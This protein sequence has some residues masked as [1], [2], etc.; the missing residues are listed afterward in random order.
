ML[1]VALAAAQQM[2]TQNECDANQTESHFAPLHHSHEIR[3]QFLEPF[4]RRI[5][6]LLNERKTRS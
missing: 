5:V 4:R 6:G 1:S 3:P 2:D